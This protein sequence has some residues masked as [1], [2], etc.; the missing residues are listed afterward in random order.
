MF[1]IY[2]CSYLQTSDF[3]SRTYLKQKDKVTLRAIIK[4]N[5]LNKHAVWC[6]MGMEQYTYG[7]E[8]V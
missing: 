7:A 1:V 8:Y 4:P 2:L 5:T 3:A 6:H